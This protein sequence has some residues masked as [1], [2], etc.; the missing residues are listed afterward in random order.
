M[1]GGGEGDAFRGRLAV[2]R[3]AADDLLLV[4]PLG[5]EPLTLEGRPLVPGD[6]QPL[7]PGQ[8]VRDRWGNE[9]AASQIEAAFTA[10]ASAAA[11]NMS[12]I[13][14]MCFYLCTVESTTSPLR[15]PVSGAGC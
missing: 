14:F 7:R 11:V 6:V 8:V 5:D 12:G 1:L 3:L 13:F 2:L 10:K 15:L 9:L 4:A